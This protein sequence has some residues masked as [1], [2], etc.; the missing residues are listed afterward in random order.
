MEILNEISFQK[1]R[2]MNINTKEGGTSD[3]SIFHFTI[4]SSAIIRS[5]TINRILQL[6]L[7]F[8]SVLISLISIK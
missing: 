6:H 1:K 8:S 7:S 3:P 5:S 4:P 2:I